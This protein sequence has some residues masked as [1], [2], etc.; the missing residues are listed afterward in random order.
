MFALD[1]IGFKAK[2]FTLFIAFTFVGAYF[3]VSFYSTKFVFIQNAARS[4]I[5]SVRYPMIVI[6]IL[7]AEQ[8]V[9]LRNVQR[10]LF[11]TQARAYNSMNIKV[12]FLL[13]HETPSLE[14]ERR[15]NN[16]IFY[17]N[18]TIHGWNKEFAK[19]LHSWY[20]FVATT[21]PGAALVGRMDDDVFCCT[22]QIFDRLNEIK[23]PFL[24]YGYRIYV[25]QK[26]H[27]NDCVDDMFVFV[28]MELVRRIASRNFC[29]DK[30]EETCLHD[31]LGW[32]RLR[33]WISPF[34]KETRFVN[35]QSKMIFFFDNTK[36]DPH[37]NI[38][39]NA[40]MEDLYEKYKKDFCK[41]H[42]LFHK[43]SVIYIYE[44]NKENGLQLGDHRRVETVEEIMKA[45]NCL[46]H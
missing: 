19:K 39:A 27:T 7:S 45:D 3:I 18:T 44:M 4:D 1:I 32:Q 6:G 13:D 43:A 15:L 28:G 30:Y 42:L 20:R 12:F 31:G 11:V 34:S 33:E 17:F 2:L 24:Y 5:N 16:D 41:K 46:R 38:S 21:Y 14:Q 35:D 36:E 40:K 37:Y 26:C 29:V 23:D 25:P 9:C 10:K 22:P 8:N